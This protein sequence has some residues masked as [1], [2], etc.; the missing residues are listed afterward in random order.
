MQK[1]IFQTMVRGQALPAATPGQLFFHNGKN[2][3]RSKI[4]KKLPVSTFFIFVLLCLM[5]FPA[6]SEESKIA[7]IVRKYKSSFYIVQMEETQNR[8]MFEIQKKN[9][10]KKAWK[11]L[12]SFDGKVVNAD[13]RIIQSINPYSHKIEL[14]SIEEYNE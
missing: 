10:D 12:K 3:M 1:L 7:G 5:A 9:S 6:F 2:I 4:M 14:L 11:M 8:T 13:C